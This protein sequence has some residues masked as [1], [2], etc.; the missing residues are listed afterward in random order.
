MHVGHEPG[1]VE[2]ESQSRQPSEIGEHAKESMQP[3]QSDQAE[4]K[5]E[6]IRIHLDDST[7]YLYR[8]RPADCDSECAM[9]ARVVG[10]VV[11]E[12]ITGDDCQAGVHGDCSAG[13]QDPVPAGL[14]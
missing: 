9:P 12:F 7:R 2:T 5:R 10:I 8:N 13:L 3:L 4:F 6:D 1:G 11:K 14:V